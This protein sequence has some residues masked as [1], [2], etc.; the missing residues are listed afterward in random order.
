V[1]EYK[2]KQ[3]FKAVKIFDR[4]WIVTGSLVVARRGRQHWRAISSI[5]FDIRYLQIADVNEI[6]FTFFVDTAHVR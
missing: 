4:R 3:P 5:D 6:Q 2:E 1:I